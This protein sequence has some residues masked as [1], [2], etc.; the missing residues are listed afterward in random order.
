MIR[1]ADR[2]APRH[3]VRAGVERRANRVV[4][5]LLPVARAGRPRAGADLVR[6]RQRE[7]AERRRVADTHGD[8]RGSGLGILRRLLQDGGEQQRHDTH[9]NDTSSERVVTNYSTTTDTWSAMPEAS[10]ARMV[11]RPCAIGQRS[12]RHGCPSTYQR[13]PVPPTARNATV[14]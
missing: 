7:P 4:D 5:E 1:V 8:A 11:W 14:A 3:A 9:A 6:R 10:T 2:F 12:L 13:T